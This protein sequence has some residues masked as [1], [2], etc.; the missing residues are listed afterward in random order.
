MSIQ[1][2]L[3][4]SGRVALITG[5]SRGLGLQIAEALAEQGAT[6]V[7]TA[8]KAEQLEEAK[9]HLSHYDT[10]VHTISHNL[11]QVDTIPELVTGI[12]KQTKTIDILVNNAG[13]TWGAP[14]ESYP[15]DAWDKVITLNLT[16]LFALTQEVARQTMIP[17]KAG[18]IVNVASVAGLQGNHPQMMGTVAYNTSKGGLIAM[19]RALAAEWARYGVRVN[20]L[21]PGFFPTRMT[22][23]T[24]EKAQSAI[25]AVTPLGRVGGP[26]DLKGAALLLASDASAF[27]TGQ[28]IVVDGGISVI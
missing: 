3:N 25:E 2:L 9:A 7:L 23:G 6:L 5:G 8:R 14:A 27:I 19:T 21:A 18:A 26:E 1:T 10:I 28:V 20:A 4:L 15:A 17:C 22:A 12:L 16:A 24:L 11:S 13:A